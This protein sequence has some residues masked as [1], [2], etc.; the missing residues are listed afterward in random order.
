MLSPKININLKLSSLI[1]IF[2]IMGFT[3]VL[4]KSNAYILYGFIPL[5]ILLSKRIS[6]Y[7]FFIIFVFFAL[8]VFY[9]YIHGISA[10]FRVLKTLIIFLPFFFTS[11]IKKSKFELSSLFCYFMRINAVLVCVDFILFLTIGNTIF[12]AETSGFMPRTCGLFEDSNFFSYTMIIYIYYI[13]WKYEKYD[14]LCV[15]SLFLSGSLSAIV[16]FLLLYIVFRSK[17]TQIENSKLRYLIFILTIFGIIT[18]DLLA[19]HSNAILDYIFSLQ[20][21]ELLEVKIYSMSHRF[22]AVSSAFS[23]FGTTHQILYGIGAGKTRTLSGIGLNL[24]NSLLQIIL[25][26]GFVLF[27]IVCLIIIVMVHKMRDLRFVILFCAILFL[28]SIMETIYSPILS[29]VYFLSLAKYEQVYVKRPNIYHNIYLKG[30][31]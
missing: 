29:L 25:E 22:T 27:T 24:H 30:K 15:L 28:S 6:I 16:T 19:I 26:M 9:L 2:F 10:S 17:K 11:I 8:A 31:H 18:Y 1:E 20:W 3:L 13:K 5:F 23:D 14:K 21:N 7:N 4:Y 12:R